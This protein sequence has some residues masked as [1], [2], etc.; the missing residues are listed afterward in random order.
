MNLEQWNEQERARLATL[1][2]TDSVRR[3]II[4]LAEC[5]C[6]AETKDGCIEASLRLQAQ[7]EELLGLE[8]PNG[9]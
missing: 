7:V 3:E 4:R 1:M 9:L 8:F 5:I 2:D 6:L